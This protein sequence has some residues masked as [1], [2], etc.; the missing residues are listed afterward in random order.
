MLFSFIPSVKHRR[1][2][3]EGKQC[4]GENGEKTSENGLGNMY[5]LPTMHEQLLSLGVVHHRSDT[6]HKATVIFEDLPNLVSICEPL[7]H[8]KVWQP[9]E[10]GISLHKK[11]LGLCLSIT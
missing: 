2:Q 11:N 7:N 5:K 9:F 8:I 4:L 3:A 6:R 10:V 1:R